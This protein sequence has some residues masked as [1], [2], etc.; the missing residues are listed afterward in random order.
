MA[1]RSKTLFVAALATLGSE[2]VYTVPAGYRV[3]L[4]SLYGLYA[5]TQPSR[6]TLSIDRPALQNGVWL[7]AVDHTVV[8]AFAW[9]GWVVLEAGDRILGASDGG[10]CYMWGSGPILPAP[11]AVQTLPLPSPPPSGYPP[12]FPR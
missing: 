9:T 3:I 8:E 7:Y 1:T 2:V 5:Y 10:L 12:W 6:V 4:K 11:P